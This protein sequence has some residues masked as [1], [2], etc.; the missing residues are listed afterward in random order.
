[1]NAETD[2]F[3]SYLGLTGMERAEGRFALLWRAAPASTW[4]SRLRQRRT[5]SCSTSRSQDWRPAERTRVAALVKTISRQIPVLLVEHDIDRVF[6]IADEVTVMNEG[7]VLVHGSVDDARNNAKVRE[8]YIG[9]GT[10]HVA[11][12]PPPSAAGAANLLS[13]ET[14]TRSM[15]RATSST[16]SRSMSP[17]TRSSRCSAATAPENRRC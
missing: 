15:A 4:G 17:R 1:V 12:A 13:V 8:I 6:Q 9:S 2:A 7:A 16:P 14:S 5:F 11:A 3:M 10:A